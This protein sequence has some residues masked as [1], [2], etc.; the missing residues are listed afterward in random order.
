MPSFPKYPKYPKDVYK[1]SAR[2]LIIIVTCNRKKKL[3]DPFKDC[4]YT[5]YSG[6]GS[7][8]VDIT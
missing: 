1:G 6:N 8:G 7:K 4:L 2:N 3:K 5:K